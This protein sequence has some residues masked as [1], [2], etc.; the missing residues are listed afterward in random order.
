MTRNQYFR[1]ERHW[2]MTYT[3]ITDWAYS[4]SR[5]QGE[6][7]LVFLMDEEKILEYSKM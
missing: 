6:I 1:K 2:K 4:S 3:L 7:G 5:D